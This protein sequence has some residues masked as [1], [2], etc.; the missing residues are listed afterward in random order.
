[1]VG[2]RCLLENLNSHYCSCQSSVKYSFIMCIQTRRK[3]QYKT[4]LTL[5]P[6]LHVK[7]LITAITA[8]TLTKRDQSGRGSLTST[9]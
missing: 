4:E 5:L 2:W 9:R 6:R 1:M 3:G 8:I 7:L